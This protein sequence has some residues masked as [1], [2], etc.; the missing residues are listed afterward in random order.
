MP[1]SIFKYKDATITVREALGR[2]EVDSYNAF[3][4]LV[5]HICKQEKHDINQ[6]PSHILYRARWTAEIILRSTVEGDLGFPFPTNISDRDAI[7]A[8]HDNLMNAPAKLANQWDKA[9]RDSDF[10]TPDPKE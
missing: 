4:E 5:E 6:V 3:L 1:N 7:K 9:E 10:E 8:F 2:D